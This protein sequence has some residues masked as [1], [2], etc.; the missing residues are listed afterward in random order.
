MKSNIG[1]RKIS[2][3][4]I[5]DLISGYELSP[6]A[7]VPAKSDLQLFFERLEEGEMMGPRYPINAP[8]LERVYS[9][10]GVPEESKKF[11]SY[12]LGKLNEI[13]DITKSIERPVEN[14]I[15]ACN[16]YLSTTEPS[17]ELSDR[18]TRLVP[19]DAKAL[20]MKRKNLSV[21]VESLPQS[22]SIS[23]DALSSGEK[24]M[25]SL[26]AKLYLYPK[27]KIVL[28]D[29]PELSL[30]IDWQRGILVDV[31]LSP[32]CEQVVAITHSPF[33]FDNALEP[34]ARSLTLSIEPDIE[35]T[36][37]FDEGDMLG[38]GGADVF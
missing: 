13:V 16:R 3:N 24:Q 1:Y 11:L 36:L 34:F 12:F 27:K 15:D 19:I 37:T 4:I 14:F 22:V 31:L 9:G 25:I 6:D 33:V 2:E 10:E 30:S 28:I 18:T 21:Y 32:L 38:D 23:L 5:Y 26:L 8:D 7:K 20:R 17:T 29:E 35:P